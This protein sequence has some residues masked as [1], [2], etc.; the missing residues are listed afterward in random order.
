VLQLGQ[1]M[2]LLGRMD[3][4][5]YLREP[6]E[7]PFTLRRH[8]NQQR[9]DRGSLARYEH[10]S[11]CDAGAGDSLRGGTP[12]RSMQL[13]TSGF[14]LGAVSS[15]AGAICQ[16]CRLS[17]ASPGGGFSGRLTLRVAIW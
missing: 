15:S 14:A 11:P 2:A 17:S 16:A 1:D 13:P 3:R 12:M 9:D 4:Q 6:Q 5:V 7:D 8:V 10:P